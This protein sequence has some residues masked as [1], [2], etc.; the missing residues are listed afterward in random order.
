MKKTLIGLIS[1]GLLNFTSILN[2][3]EYNR[4]VGSFNL[5]EKTQMNTTTIKE[6]VPYFQKIITKTPDGYHEQINQGYYIREKIIQTPITTYEWQWQTNPQ[7]QPQQQLTQQ[8]PQVI[9]VMPRRTRDP[10]CE[11]IAGALSLPCQ[12]SRDL[13]EPIRK[14]CSTPRV[15]YVPVQI[16]QQ[17]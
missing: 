9:Y 16:Q 10:L 6:K 8:Q 1:L 7:P 11:F 15:I 3:Q 17:R 12:L 2:A 5:V 13:T 4:V 14:N